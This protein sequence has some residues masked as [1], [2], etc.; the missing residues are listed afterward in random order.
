M[1]QKLPS[2]DHSQVKEQFL[3]VYP[4]IAVLILIAINAGV[5]YLLRHSIAHFFE[6]VLK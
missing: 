2:P 3:R 6:A 1:N 5:F 4:Y